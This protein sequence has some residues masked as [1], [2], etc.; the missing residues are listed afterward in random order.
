M[1]D[2]EIVYI[3]KKRYARRK[4]WS[5]WQ[6]QQSKISHDKELKVPP[7]NLMHG[8]KKISSKNGFLRWNKVSK[9][10]PQV[11]GTWKSSNIVKGRIIGQ[12]ANTK[13]WNGQGG[14]NLHFKCRC[15]AI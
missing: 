12:L 7:E 5:Q 9:C 13:K 3:L 15:L 2:T 4:G 14:L 1:G 10:E 6:G 11:A 8:R